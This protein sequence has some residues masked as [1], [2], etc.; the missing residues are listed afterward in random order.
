MTHPSV[1]RSFE[2]QSLEETSVPCSSPLR[3]S[4]YSS[5]PGAPQWTVVAAQGPKVCFSFQLPKTFFLSPNADLMLPS[6]FQPNV[7]K[8]LSLFLSLFFQWISC[9]LPFFSSSVLLLSSF[10]LSPPPLSHG[11]LPPHHFLS[12]HFINE[13]AK[14]IRAQADGCLSF[15]K[16]EVKVQSECARALGMSSNEQQQQQQKRA[17]D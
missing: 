9:Q 8:L 11:T 5:S 16:A 2:V 13:L 14:Q 4:V 1:R 7:P 3:A 12:L 17:R 15:L 6:T 10:Q